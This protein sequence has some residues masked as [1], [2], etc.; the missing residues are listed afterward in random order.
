MPELE[1]LQNLC[2]L[3]PRQKSNVSVSDEQLAKDA[4]LLPPLLPNEPVSAIRAAISEIKGYAHLTSY[5]LVVEDLEDRVID[6]IIDE[7][8]AKQKAQEENVAAA[9]EKSKAVASTTTNVNVA[10][11]GKKK[12]K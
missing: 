12:K 6:L 7:T 5:R 10:A 4:I 2:I 9:A 8:R 1:F 3:P 11:G